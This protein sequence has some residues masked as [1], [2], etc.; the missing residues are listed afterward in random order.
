MLGARQ[1]LSQAWGW[2]AT[3][4]GGCQPLQSLYAWAS[5]A[6]ALEPLLPAAR[7]VALADGHVRDKQF[8]SDAWRS[9]RRALYEPVEPWR[10]LGLLGCEAPREFYDSCGL[11]PEAEDLDALCEDTM[12]GTPAPTPSALDAT[13]PQGAGANVADGAASEDPI[14]L[15]EVWE[16]DE[17]VGGEALPEAPT[18]DE[19]QG[20]WQAAEPPTASEVA[21][22][23]G[24]EEQVDV[25]PDQVGDE[26]V[27]PDDGTRHDPRN[28]VAS[29]GFVDDFE[30]A[31]QA[32]PASPTSRGIVSRGI[33]EMYAEEGFEDDEGEEDEASPGQG[34]DDPS[35]G[36]DDYGED[37]DFEPDEGADAPAG[38]N[39]AQA[40][41]D[42]GYSF[43]GD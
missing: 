38:V 20:E 22:D 43:E 28:G 24:Q 1:L 41:L 19:V 33:S 40:N 14:D 4:C 5:L 8:T 31:S 13:T 3:G 26:E 25:S 18:G 37:Y 16:V 6:V 35:E 30:D 21:I 11:Q 34:G 36:S 12:A 39:E 32:S 2:F 27:S 17:K 7:A 23:M 29:E 10:W 9:A 42:G 15:K